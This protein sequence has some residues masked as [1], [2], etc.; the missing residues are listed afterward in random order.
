MQNTPRAPQ[1]KYLIPQLKPSF[2]S[3]RQKDENLSFDEFE[4]ENAN[5]NFEDEIF[6][7]KNVYPSFDIFKEEFYNTNPIF[8]ALISQ[9]NR[10][11]SYSSIETKDSDTCL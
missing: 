4:I 6:E 5:K 3:L 8:N 7:I 2:L 10:T 9:K 1:A 11:I